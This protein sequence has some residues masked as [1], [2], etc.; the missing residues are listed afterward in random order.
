M[1][2]NENKAVKTNDKK[3]SFWQGVKR[4]WNKIIWVSKE[5]LMKETGVVVVISLLM[6]LI[7]TAVDSGALR[8]ID[9]ILAI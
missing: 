8:L 6:G 5:D 1:A 2:D 7:I 4:E 9:L 3:P